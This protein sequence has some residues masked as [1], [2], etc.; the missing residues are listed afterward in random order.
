MTSNFIIF[1]LTHRLR[2]ETRISSDLVSL[3][4]YVCY[5]ITEVLIKLFQKPQNHQ[6]TIDAKVL[7]FNSL[8]YKF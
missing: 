5:T 4:R 6:A 3:K 7:F 8:N 1:Q 2:N